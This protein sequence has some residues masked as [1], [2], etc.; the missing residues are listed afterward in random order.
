MA[1]FF[2][3]AAFRTG[4]SGTIADAMTLF[5]AEIACN[6]GGGT[7]EFARKFIASGF[8]MTGFLAKGTDSGEED[9]TGQSTSWVS[10]LA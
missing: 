8:G 6:R 10:G 4:E 3:I 2:A 5:F 9:R 7:G 1:L